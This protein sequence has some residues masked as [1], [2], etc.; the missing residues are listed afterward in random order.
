MILKINGESREVSDGMT[1]EDLV[2]ELE[3]KRAGIAVDVNREVVPRGSYGEK[4][5]E[6]GDRV[7][8]IRMVGGG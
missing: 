8:I 1:L 3:I 4:V 2:E 7:E 6:E 5:L